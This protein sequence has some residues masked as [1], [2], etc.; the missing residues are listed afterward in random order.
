MQSSHDKILFFFKITFV[1]LVIFLTV[2]FLPIY[3]YVDYYSSIRQLDEVNF[4]EFTPHYLV[5][6]Y[7]KN[8]DFKNYNLNFH[9]IF[10]FVNLIILIIP[11]I[12]HFLLH[13]NIQERQNVLNIFLS[14]LLFPITLQSL[15]SPNI[16]SLFSLIAVYLISLIL[17]LKN[18][19]QITT[20]IFSSLFIYLYFV[21]IGNWFVLLCFI[22]FV[23]FI[24]IL[25]YLTN[26]KVCLVFFVIIIILVYLFS[27]QL[28][29]LVG[30]LFD[31][32]QTSL[33]IFD[34]QILELVNPDLIEILK[35]SVYYFLTLFGLINHL[36]ILILS[37]IILLIILILFIVYETIRNFDKYKNEFY[38]SQN[39]VTYLSVMIFPLIIIM[40]L[41]THAYA[42]YFIFI[43]PFIMKFL[44]IYFTH[45]KLFIFSS[46]YSLCFIFN[47]YILLNN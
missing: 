21:D 14:S 5:I 3:F 34:L 26:F 43:V 20:I 39:F 42:Q 9:K 4:S 16:E 40:V 13:K 35:R 44:T 18:K 30:S 27:N 1:L 8:E 29:I 32:Y 12:L 17:C 36:E 24:F 11:V 37:T 23:V 2:Q 6:D 41:P 22:S 47:S 31:S 28:L 38:S 45:N 19:N 10:N 46:L 7:L 25:N 33:L 15:A